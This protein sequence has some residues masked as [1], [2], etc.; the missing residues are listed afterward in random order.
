MIAEI[1]QIALILAL[2]VALAQSVLPMWGA[3]SANSRL[4][5]FGDRSATMQFVLIAI[6]F[7]ALTTAFINSDLS[8][9]LVAV[10]SHAD[11]PLL[12]KI[13]GVWG[14][15][16]G[17]MLLWVLILSIYGALVPKY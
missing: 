13:S 10:N 15:H 8:V 17:S 11:K 16:E 12:Y 6:A 14:N 9:K 3:H 2:L 7:A 1:G 4:M 5:A